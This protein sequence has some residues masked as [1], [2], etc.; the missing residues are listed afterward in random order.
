MKL[1]D[2]YIKL[3]SDQINALLFGLPSYAIF[4]SNIKKEK[5]ENKKKKRIALN[6]T[7]R[8]YKGKII[9]RTSYFRTL[10][11]FFA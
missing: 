2:A 5:K 9:I 3:K 8:R 10:S 1:I 7:H 11:V 4:W 6:H